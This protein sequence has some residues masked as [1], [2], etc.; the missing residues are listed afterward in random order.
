MPFEWSKSNA[1]SLFGLRR[2][3]NALS[4]L[5]LSSP[6]GLMLSRAIPACQL[7]ASLLKGQPVPGVNLSASRGASDI[8]NLVST[9][10]VWK[11]LN[12]Q[13]FIRST[14]RTYIQSHAFDRCSYW[15]DLNAVSTDQVSDEAHLQG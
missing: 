15:D 11:L 4:P 9:W 14:S 13:C 3:S 1:L 10:L 6:L 8:T 5:G 12:P 7:P 2:R